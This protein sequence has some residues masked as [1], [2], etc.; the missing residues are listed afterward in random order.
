MMMMHLKDLATDD[1]SIAIYSVAIL[2]ECHD[3]DDEDDKDDEDDETYESNLV[4]NVI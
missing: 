4:K 2:G 3:E 1:L